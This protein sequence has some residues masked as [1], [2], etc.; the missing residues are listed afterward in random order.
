MPETGGTVQF[1]I[2]VTNNSLE[3]A[4][5]DSLVDSDFNLAALCPGAVGT[6][7]A[8]HQTYTCVFSVTVA[9]DYESGV[10]HVNTAT[11]VASDDDGNSDTASDD[12]TVTFTDMT[13]QIDIEKYVSVD[14]GAT[15]QDADTATGP[16]LVAGT[17]P[18]FKFVVTNTGAVALSSL[19]LSDTDFTAFYASD[20]QTT[21]AIPATLAPA[22]SFSCYVGSA[23]N[24]GQHANTATA[25]GSFVDGAGNT[26]SD[27]DTDAAHYFGANPSFAVTKVCKAG[28][29]PIPQEG[30]ALF[31]VAFHNDGN[32]P[33][34]I[35]ADD[36]IG[37]FS[38]A[39]GETKT[40]DVA[41][42]GPFS[43]LATADNTIH[44]TSTY[45]DDA[46]HSKSVERSDGA[47]C[48]VGSRVNVLKLTQDGVDPSKTWTFN[49]WQGAG[50]FG[51]TLLASTNSLGD[52]D[53]VLDFGNLNLR[54]DSTYTLCELAVPA[55]WTPLWQVDTNHDGV[56]D[57]VLTPYNPN[58]TDLP[59]QDLGN[60]C[61]D[62]GAGTG[63][64]LLSD[65]GTLL[66]QVNN[67][68]TNEGGEPRTPGY[69]KNW[70]RC[71]GGGRRKTQT[72]MAAGKPASGCWRMCS[73][74]TS[75]G[76]SP[77]MTSWRMTSSSRSRPA[78][79]PSISSTIA[80]LPIRPCRSMAP[81]TPATQP[82]R[83]P[84]TCWRPNLTSAPG[85]APAM[86][87][88]TL[89]WKA[90]SC[91]ISTI[92]T[93]PA[94]ICSA[95]TRSSRQT[96]TWRSNWQPPWMNTTTGGCAPVP[97]CHLSALWTATRSPVISPSRSV[98]PMQPP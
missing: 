96:M 41:L 25:S 84:C 49:L 9:G 32:V 11:V 66:F 85:P 15:W 87:R 69:W 36:G 39:I 26:E 91:W 90:K 21:C 34:S 56:V 71:T 61:V 54:A 38:L 73:I 17:H 82:I 20:L 37:T 6:V 5:I 53:G 80:K 40:F 74:R 35:T 44:A 63:V 92:S 2:V 47:A 8:Y 55:G 16:Y 57:T 18:Q 78:P 79:W 62:F 42:N 89:R 4:T 77:G 19:S 33:L 23:W 76:A 48:R 29:E 43:G 88:P 72:A 58:A 12:A 86:R 60:R 75:A 28:A 10:P 13:P 52:A 7:L 30:P 98:W 51:G 70:N 81:P 45:R 50:G 24:A 59:P 46:G 64:D 93:A 83:W 14:G 31:T 94:T 22:A 68:Y 65:G 3:A 97:A 27:S 67:T 95:A 1:T